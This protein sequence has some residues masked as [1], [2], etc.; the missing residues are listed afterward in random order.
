MEDKMLNLIYAV[1]VGTAS[2]RVVVSDIWDDE[3]IVKW[4]IEIYLG[5][6]SDD[7]SD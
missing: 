3:E 6:V 1:I 5:E 4:L 2:G 7:F